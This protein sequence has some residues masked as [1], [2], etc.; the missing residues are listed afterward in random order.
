MFPKK[1]IEF[2]SET[3]MMKIAHSRSRLDVCSPA[4]RYRYAPAHVTRV[5]STTTRARQNSHAAAA[6]I[7]RTHTH[8]SICAIVL[9]GGRPAVS[10]YTYSDGEKLTCDNRVNIP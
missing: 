10:C 7:V 4:R 2:Y 5:Y 6:V 9:I 3:I 1:T 8:I